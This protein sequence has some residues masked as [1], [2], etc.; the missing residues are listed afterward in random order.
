LPLAIQK[1]LVSVLRATAQ[2]FRM[3]CT[4]SEDLEK[5]T[6]EGTF[7]D[8]LFYRVASLPVVLPPLRDRA[9]DIPMLVKH[10]ASKA[11]NPLFDA[12]LLE[13]TDDAMEVLKTYD[14]PCNLTEL[15]Q[16]VTKLAATAETRVV[17]SQELPMRLKEVKKWPS[18]ADYLAGQQKQYVDMVV[19]ACGD[20]KAKA[21]KVL[22]IDVAK[23]K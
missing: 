12:S 9:D 14:W 11:T 10:F 6:D 1:E 16:V 7:H 5:L 22:G 15:H 8:E 3:V 18:L 21:A 19:H 23:I 20:D 4:T 17:T 13:V 2:G